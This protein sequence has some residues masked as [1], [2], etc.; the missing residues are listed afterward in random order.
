[1]CAGVSKSG[2]PISRWT[3]S[4]P[5][6]SRALARASTSKADSVPRR[7]MRPAKFMVTTIIL[8]GM[9]LVEVA[10]GWFWMGWE[11]GHPGERPRHRVWLDEFSIASAPVTN[12]EY[13]RFLEAAEAAPPPWW[14][15]L[16]F[17][18]PGQPVVGVNW[19]EAALYCDWLS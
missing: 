3:I 8:D 6:R 4:L 17:N 15:D 13:A 12:R 10:A 14:D 5:C 16:R 1:M 2:S 11:G 18:D 9:E 7:D 19:F